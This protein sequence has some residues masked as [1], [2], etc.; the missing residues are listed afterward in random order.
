[1]MHTTVPSAMQL[2]GH[3]FPRTQLTSKTFSPGF[4]S[5]TVVQPRLIET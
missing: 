3:T 1:L 4:R 2:N 5:F